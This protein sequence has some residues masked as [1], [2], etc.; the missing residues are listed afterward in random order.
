MTA[1]SWVEVARRPKW[2]AGLF[3]ALAVAAV[4][5]LLGQWQLERTFTT[6]EPSNDDETVFN[7]LDVAE[8]GQPISAEAAN[9]LVSAEIY[10]DLAN[11]YIVSNRIQQRNS[12]R[13]LGYWL[14]SN[15]S[16]LLENSDSTGS[17]T[18]ALGFADSLEQA[19]LAR[20]EIK[21]SIQ[22]D[23]FIERVGRYLQSEAPVELPDSDKP[24]LLG[25][26]SLAQLVNLYSSEPVQSFAGIMALSE[27]PGFSLET[28]S[29]APPRLEPGLIG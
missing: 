25:S 22:V 6:V 29:I 11:V 23:A 5:A 13:V 1:P 17:L 12:D 10:L 19:E 8:V 27:S 2:I 18:I 28:I 14:V 9:K 15:S 4:F 21:N 24:Y 16:V 20:E 3:L 7:L 26:L